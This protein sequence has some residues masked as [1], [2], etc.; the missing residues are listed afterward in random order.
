MSNLIQK[1][2][3]RQKTDPDW[4]QHIVDQI[5]RLEYGVVQITVHQGAVAQVDVTERRRFPAAS[6]R[7][8]RR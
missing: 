2:E 5:R 1:P 4:V 3:E 7:D 8:G 6:G